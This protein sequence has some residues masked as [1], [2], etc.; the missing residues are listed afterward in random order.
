MR[1]WN[2]NLPVTG[3]HTWQHKPP[4]WQKQ[5]VTRM[6]IS[7]KTTI[8]Q[9]LLSMHAQQCAEHVLS[10][11]DS[12]PSCLRRRISNVP[13]RDENGNSPEVMFHPPIRFRPAS[14]RVDTNHDQRENMN[15][16]RTGWTRI[17]A[18]HF[19]TSIKTTIRQHLLSMNA[20][21]C[22]EHM[23][24]L[25]NSAPSCPNDPSRKLRLMCPGHWNNSLS[26]LNMFGMHLQL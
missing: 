10:L 19:V 24:S 9:Y 15:S 7:V 18:R 6:Q 22:A 3:C 26:D 16:C 21:Q 17:C 2:R 1:I 13:S 23:L 8:H 12:A 25:Q 5:K 11:R 14:I 4:I 20:Q